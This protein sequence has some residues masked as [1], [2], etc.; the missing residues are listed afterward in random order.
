MIFPEFT[1]RLPTWIDQFTGTAPKTFATDEEKMDWVIELSRHNIANGGG[2][3][4][5]AIFAVDSGKLIAPGVNL[6]V[7]SNSSVMHAEMVAI[8]VAQQ[9]LGRYT[10]GADPTTKFELVS[11]TEPCAMCMGAIPWAGISRLLYG[12]SDEDARKI[13]FD[14]GDKPADWQTCYAQR[15]IEVVSELCRTEAAQ[16]L[17]AYGEQEGV[18]YN[19]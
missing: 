4:G 11:S 14:E 5:A 1:L 7:P 6:V 13:G 10:L 15:G 2:P 12:A 18:L 9:C 3:F 16:V 8:M 19:G 17:Q